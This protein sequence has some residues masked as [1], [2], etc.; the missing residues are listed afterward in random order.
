MFIFQATVTKQQL[1]ISGYFIL[2]TCL[3]AYGAASRELQDECKNDWECRDNIPGSH[4]IEGR[5]ACQPYF[6]KINSTL[7]LP[8]KLNI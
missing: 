1:L 2:Q 5:C 4:C 6:A 7:C 3:L 8:C